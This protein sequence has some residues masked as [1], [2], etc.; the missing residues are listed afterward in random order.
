MKKS[1]RITL[2]CALI[3]FGAVFFILPGTIFIL[4]A[5]LLLLSY[6]IPQARSALQVLQGKASSSARKL[7]TYLLRRKLS[8]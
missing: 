3:L 8:R 5:G 6:D 2:G 1:V 7:D 4:M